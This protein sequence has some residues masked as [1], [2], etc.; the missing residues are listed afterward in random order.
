MKLKLLTAIYLSALAAECFANVTGNL[1]LQFVSKPSLMLI[2][3]VYFFGET[4]KLNDLKYLITGALF[5]S[6]LGDVVL[7]LD[8]VYKNLFVFGLVSFLVAHI[9][10]IFYFWRVRNY[11]LDRKAIKPFVLIAVAAYSATFYA[12]LFPSLAN[13]KIPVL[14]YSAVISL[15]LI[16]SFHAFDLSKQNFGRLCVFGTI[17]FTISDSILA[18]NRFVY[19][20]A[21]APVF[22]MLTYGIAQFLITEGSLRNLREIEIK[23]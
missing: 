15:M 6:W 12:A 5:F 21:L 16:T 17:L 14:V 11:N 1:A 10:Y 7:L 20:F 8:K 22:I 9:F 19:P 4:R 23:E 13:M 18:V 2:L 3:I